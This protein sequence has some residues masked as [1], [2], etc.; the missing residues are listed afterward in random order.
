VLPLMRERWVKRGTNVSKVQFTFSVQSYYYYKNDSSKLWI[1]RPFPFEMG[2][3]KGAKDVAE[4]LQRWGISCAS[5]PL[6]WTTDLPIPTQNRANRARNPAHSNPKP[7]F[8]RIK[9]CPLDYARTCRHPR[10]ASDLS[11]ICRSFH[12][13]LARCSGNWHSYTGAITLYT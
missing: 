7:P 13:S 5:C 6:V 9:P 8:C 1:T 3:R 4:R 11:T 2:V 10:S 12:E